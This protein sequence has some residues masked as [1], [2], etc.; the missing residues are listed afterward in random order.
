MEST[1]TKST[2][3]SLDGTTSIDLIHD[4]NGTRHELKIDEKYPSLSK[5]NILNTLVSMK[6]LTS[7]ELRN[8]GNEMEWLD[9]VGSV[10]K[11][12]KELRWTIR[13]TW[14]YGVIQ[15]IEDV[16]S[17][18]KKLEVL[19]LTIPN[20]DKRRLAKRMEEYLPILFKNCASLKELNYYLSY[21]Q[22]PGEF[23]PRIKSKCLKEKKKKLKD[24]HLLHCTNAETYPFIEWLQNMQ[25]KKEAVKYDLHMG[26]EFE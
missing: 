18:C 11:E 22:D 14:Q 16:T 5:E 13:K 1:I 26:F 15:G 4:Y 17:G 24:C 9:G 25:F 19:H 12:L 7:L 21:H 6:G 2:L 20:V 8:I 10:C 23:L 3:V